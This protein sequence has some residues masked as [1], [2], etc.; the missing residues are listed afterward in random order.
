M[1]KWQWK[2]FSIATM[3]AM[4]LALC[5][6]TAVRAAPG[7]ATI[8][9][10]IAMLQPE[11]NPGANF[12]VNAYPVGGGDGNCNGVGVGPGDYNIAGYYEYEL[13]NCDSS[14]DYT[15]IAQG[16][17]YTFNEVDVDHTNFAGGPP[18]TQIADPITPVTRTVSGY[19]YKPNGSGFVGFDLHYE[20]DGTPHTVTTLGGGAFTIP[21]VTDASRLY[22]PRIDMDGYNFGGDQ[23]MDPPLQG[24]VTNEDFKSRGTRNINGHIESRNAIRGCTAGVTITVTEADALTQTYVTDGDGSFHLENLEPLSDYVVT[25]SRTGC[26][27]TPASQTIDITNGNLNQDIVFK[28]PNTG[29]FGIVK[30]TLGDSTLTHYASLAYYLIAT[31]TTADGVSYSTSVNWA[32]GSYSISAPPSTGTLT[33]SRVGGPAAF[34]YQTVGS[35][36]TGITLTDEWQE[37]NFTLTPSRI[38]SGTILG[39]NGV[40]VQKNATVDFGYWLHWTQPNTPGPAYSLL[41]QPKLYYLSPVESGIISSTPARFLANL[42]TAPSVTNANFTLNL[43]TYRLDGCLYRDSNDVPVLW[44]PPTS[45]IPTLP[46]TSTVVRFRP[47]AGYGATLYPA[48]LAPDGCGPNRYYYMVTLPKGIAGAMEADNHTLRYSTIDGMNGDIWIDMPVSGNRAITGHIYTPNP[49]L[50]ISGDFSGNGLLVLRDAATNDLVRTDGDMERSMEFSIPTLESKAYTVSINQGQIPNGYDAQPFPMS[51]IVTANLA[52]GDVDIPAASGFVLV[53]KPID[54]TSATGG[55]YFLTGPSQT[56]Q[57][58]VWDYPPMNDRDKDRF[59]GFEV[60][61]GT[62]T[63]A[64]TDIPPAPPVPTPVFYQSNSAT[65]NGLTASTLY[66]WRARIVYETDKGPWMETAPVP[67]SPANWGYLNGAAAQFTFNWSAVPGAF[68]QKYVVQYSDNFTFPATTTVTLPAV[69]GTT[70][71]TTAVTPPAIGKTYFWRVKVQNSTGGDISGWSP[72][73]VF[74]NRYQPITA[75]PTFQRDT[76]DGMNPEPVRFFAASLNTTL[77]ANAYYQVELSNDGFTSDSHLFTFTRTA[78][79]ATPS[80]RQF[81]NGLGGPYAWRIRIV[82]GNDSNA[83]PITDWTAGTGTITP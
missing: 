39:Q 19:V 43:K 17:G 9:G 50:D 13:T 51:P 44:A 79:L 69:T 11:N 37:Q 32:D 80:A 48:T 65:F 77:P 22:F 61:M 74:F 38:I 47:A 33:I 53:H 72:T 15:V 35:S 18:L 58:V 64:F 20:L 78:N 41:A 59:R 75:G 36:Q 31:Y 62:A 56:S 27:F 16:S 46:F 42:T 7:D 23:W 12:N 73:Q 25:P 83:Y 68:G 71:T 4:A 63:T 40:P 76:F 54:P 81:L 66:R 55:G 28:V 8:T 52:G 6:P 10:R 21:D 67:T 45:P 30:S 49:D 5:P 24:N 2:V 14:K 34:G 57:T 26:V 82:N 60:Q 3:L 1:N 29:V 70:I